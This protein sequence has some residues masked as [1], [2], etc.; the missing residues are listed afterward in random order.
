MEPAI[1]SCKKC[2]WQG[3][4]DEVDWDVV[5]TCM[6]TDKIEICPICGNMEIYHL[7]N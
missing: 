6:G 5:E 7:Y 2:N 4:Q 3:L 1:L